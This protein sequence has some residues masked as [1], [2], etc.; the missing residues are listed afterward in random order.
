MECCFFSSSLLLLLLLL[1]DRVVFVYVYAEI[2]CQQIE[3]VLTLRDDELTMQKEWLRLK[4]QNRSRNKKQIMKE[5]S[6]NH[7][8]DSKMLQDNDERS[9]DQLQVRGNEFKQERD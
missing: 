7:V 5:Y 8:L 3:M 2:Q 6:V 9:G 1:L 4:F